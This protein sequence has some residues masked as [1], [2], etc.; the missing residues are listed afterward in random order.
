[1]NLSR[2]GFSQSFPHLWKKIVENRPFRTPT[3][4]AD[5][6]YRWYF[7]ASGERGAMALYRASQAV[8][9]R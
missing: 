7:L 2:W 6:P 9:D 8:T 3:A 5:G 1:M 4:G